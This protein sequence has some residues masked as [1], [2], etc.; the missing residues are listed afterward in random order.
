VGA[1]RRFNAHVAPPQSPP[2]QVSAPTVV[3]TCFSVT[4]AEP[5]TMTRGIRSCVTLADFANMLKWI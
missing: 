4:N 3:R 5:S 1:V 2:P